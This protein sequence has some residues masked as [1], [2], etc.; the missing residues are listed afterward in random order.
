[1]GFSWLEQNRSQVAK[2]VYRGVQWSGQLDPG[3]Q[4]R[5]QVKTEFYYFGPELLWRLHG[6]W[7]RRRDSNSRP[8]LL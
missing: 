7:R 3:V 5:D 1:M 4:D 6:Y 8:T 2:R